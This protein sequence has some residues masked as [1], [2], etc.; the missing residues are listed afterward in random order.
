MKFGFNFKKTVGKI[1][2]MHSVGQ[3]PL[4]GISDSMFHYLTE[5][6]I[7]HSRLHDVGGRFGGNMF[8]DIHN[9]FRNFD[10]D[11]NLEE[12]YDFAFTDI[13]IT[14]LIKANL[15]PVFRLGETIENFHYIKAYR[16]FPPKD[17]A[18]WARI[19]EHIIRHYNEGWANGF[20]YGIEYWEIWNEPDNGRD[21][22]ENQMWHGTMEQFFDLYEVTAKHLKSVF[23][24]SIKVGGFATCG[25]CYMLSDPQKFGIDYEPSIDKELYNL[26]RNRNYMVW[27]DSFLAHLKKTNTPIDFFSWHSYLSTEDTV[28]CA[29]Y[30]KKLLE[31]YG[32]EHIETQLNEWNNCSVFQLPTNF[33]KF[34]GTNIASARAAA[35]MLAMQ[36]YSD[37][38]ILCFYDARARGG[39]Y[40]GMFNPITLEPWP[41]YYVFSA[42]GELYRLG[43][44]VECIYPRTRGVYALGATDGKDYRAMFANENDEDIVVETNLPS[45]MLAYIIDT[46]KNLEQVLL[47]PKRF[48]LR[49][50][51]VLLFRI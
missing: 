25:F 29:Q 33:K 51:T 19:C 5:A 23:G 11:E 14:G 21:D 37:I 50:N 6:S 39:A 30:C 34:L 13:L 24:D 32:Y 42:F 28:A 2:A 38:D 46:D 27:A 36:Q 15:K 3:P 48:T 45:R 22:T 26:D 43:E 12:S 1:R 18:K 16:I 8:V 9:I 17:N 35:M 41:V 44:Q 4:V 31:K 10:A 47:D 49:A 20:H 40:G 7:Q